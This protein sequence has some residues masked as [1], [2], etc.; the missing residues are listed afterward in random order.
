MLESK[1]SLG[2]T[3]FVRNPL[4]NN[5]K[6]ARVAGFG[7]P[8]GGIAQVGVEFQEPAAEFWFSDVPSSGL[9]SSSE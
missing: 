8:Y 1:V 9:R 7:I 6:P 5:E 4:T 2:Q 3:L